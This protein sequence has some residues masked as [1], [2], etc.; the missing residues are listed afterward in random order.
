MI[1]NKVYV[2]NPVYHGVRLAV[3][4]GNWKFWLAIGMHF[5]GRLGGD[6]K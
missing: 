1:I 3:A 5:N 2:K 6:W 4:H